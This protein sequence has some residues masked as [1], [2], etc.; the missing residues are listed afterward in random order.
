MP[1][2]KIEVGSPT[3][4]ITMFSTVTAPTNWLLCD[5][6][7]VS[8]ATYSTLF[9]VIGTTYGVGNGS[10]TFNVPNL[11][12]KVPVGYDA[13]DADYNAMGETGGAKTHSHAD[14]TYAAATHTHEKGTLACAAHTHEAGSL[15]GPTHTHDMPFG[16]RTS[17][18]YFLFDNDQTGGTGTGDGRYTTWFTSDT[19]TFTK[20]KTYDGGNGAVTGTAGSRTP[21]VSGTTATRSADVSGTSAAGNGV[22][23]Y[24]ALTYIIK[25]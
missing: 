10:T 2:T 8:R 19:G 6:A 3:G 22:Q 7:A 13:S 14:G 18:N 16:P 25:T 11:K 24:I 4:S 20:F 21:A 23:P 5:G 1:Q 12:S 9:G 15:L 17:L